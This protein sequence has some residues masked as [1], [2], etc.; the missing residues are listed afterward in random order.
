MAAQLGPH[1]LLHVFS[2]LE[3]RD[4][5]RAAQVN[6]VWN[7]V[8]MTRELWRQLCLRRWASCNSFPVVLGTQTWR[9]YYFCRSEL[10]F[11]VEA[12]RPRDFISKAISGHEGKID[13]LAYISPHEYRFDE[14]ARSVVCTVSSDC[15]V[16]A[17]D[18]H[19]GTEIWSSPVQP[20]PLV[21]LV[22]YPLLQLVVTVD[23]Q[24]LIISWKADT[25]SKWASFF[26]RT[27]CSSMEACGH[28]EGPFLMVACADGNLYTLTVPQLQV[29]SKVATFPRTSVSLACS[30][31]QKWVSVLAKGSDLGLKV[32]FTQPLLHP[33]EDSFPVST[34]L[35]VRL[36]SKACWA[37][38]EAARLMVMHK[39]ES[40]VHLVITT[41]ILKASES[42]DR[43]SIQAQQLASFPLPGTMT[44][45]L[46]QGHG[47]HVILL[48]SMSELVL[49]NIH[50][51]QLVAFQDHQRPITSM[52]VD[53]NHVITSSLDLSLRVYLWDK[54]NTC[55]VL[56]SCYHL[57]G[58][59]HRW[60]S[61]FTHVKSDGVSIAGIEAR[62][63]GTSILRSYCFKVQLN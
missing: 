19:Q 50:G 20:A 59:S 31:D 48:A 46:M 1:E 44:P 55:P 13:Q 56:K 18:L 29:I 51:L 32:F 8:S 40:G 16:R 17:W 23:T 45:H 63:N 10:E 47:S 52:W 9:Q 4:L 5:L 42:R 3:A 24:G 36:S 15:T 6:K 2:F 7:E 57:L 49:F 25:G 60:A 43:V 34:T 11:R 14:M 41:F 12:G 22:A 33:L 35:P 28:P 61:G 21:T 62:S 37:P 39:D 30:P 53:P 26:L 38:A 58:G 54:K 27:S